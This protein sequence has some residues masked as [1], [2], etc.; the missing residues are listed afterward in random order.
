MGE[1]AANYYPS[2]FPTWTI[3]NYSSDDWGDRTAVG[4]LWNTMVADSQQ[5]TIWT[6]EFNFNSGTCGNTEREIADWTCK[7]YKYMTWERAFFFDID[8]GGGCF[9]LLN[10][11]GVPKSFLYPAF[12]SIVSN[13]YVCQ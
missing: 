6:T 12:T 2:Y 3:H 11:G 8:V 5:R 1:L 13:V 4:V 9:S 10:S 7:N